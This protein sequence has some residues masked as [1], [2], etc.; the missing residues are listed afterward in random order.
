[1]G[2]PHPKAELKV[3]LRIVANHQVPVGIGAGGAAAERLG[4]VGVRKHVVGVTVPLHH[5]QG[6]MEHH[7]EDQVRDGTTAQEQ[8]G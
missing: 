4:P 8:R 5:R 3:L 2:L 1:M 7:P 6:C